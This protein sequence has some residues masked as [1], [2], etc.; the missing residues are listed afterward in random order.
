MQQHVQVAF[1]DWFLHG[2][3]RLMHGL[4]KVLVLAV[5]LFR[6]THHK[7]CPPEPGYVRANLVCKSGHLMCAW[8]LARWFSQQNYRPSFFRCVSQRLFLLQP[9]SDHLSSQYR[10]EPE[11]QSLARWLLPAGLDPFGFESTLNSSK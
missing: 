8:C 1:E 10:V 4:T 7:D 3:D 9:Y 5:I 2:S 6:S 11:I